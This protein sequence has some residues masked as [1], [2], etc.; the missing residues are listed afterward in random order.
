[1]RGTPTAVEDLEKIGLLSVFEQVAALKDRYGLHAYLTALE[2]SNL[3]GK[4]ETEIRES[5]EL[6]P[7]EKSTLAFVLA[8]LVLGLAA[9]QYR[10]NH[11]IPI[12][13][14]AVVETAKAAGMPAEKR[15]EAKRRR[16]VR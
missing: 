6:T 7:E 9:K 2:N 5:R 8:A 12:P 3:R 10:A 14:T 4:L 13:K 1:M 16:A 15:A 11:S